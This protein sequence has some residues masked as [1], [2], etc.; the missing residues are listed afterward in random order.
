MS[1]QTLFMDTE[2]T[3]FKNPKL[4]SIALVALGGDEF[5]AEVEY[6]L[7]ECSDFV[8]ATV[9]PLLNQGKKP[10]FLE[11]VRAELGSWIEIIRQDRPVLI[12]YDSE[13]DRKM[14]DQIFD[15][16][17]PDGVVLRNLGPSY[18]NKL[19]QYEFHVRHKQA[20]HHA[21]HDARALKYAFRGWVRKVR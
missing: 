12:C 10:L 15:G 21:L 2:F 4:I 9:L 5:Y 6:P 16:D 19:K 18:V 7:E 20:E 3:N 11:E 13:Y 8:R 17:M 14:L 1:Q